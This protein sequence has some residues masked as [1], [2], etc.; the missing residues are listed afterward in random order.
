MAAVRPLIGGFH[1]LIFSDGLAAA[2]RRA[3]ALS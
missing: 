2:V 1:H 3:E